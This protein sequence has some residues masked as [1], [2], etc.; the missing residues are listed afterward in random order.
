MSRSVTRMRA[1]ASPGGASSVLAPATSFVVTLQAA[2]FLMVLGLGFL[3]GWKAVIIES[4]SMRPVLSPGDIVLVKH[5]ERPEVGEVVLLD[6]PGE[7]LLFHRLVDWDEEGRAITR[8]D[9][10]EVEDGAATTPDRI[11][12]VG[13]VALPSIGLPALWL[14]QG[15]WGLVALSLL[16]EVAIFFLARLSTPV[17]RTHPTSRPSAAQRPPR[18]PAPRR[19]SSVALARLGHER[20]SM[21]GFSNASR[22]FE[23]RI[24]SPSS[25]RRCG[26][27]ACCSCLESSSASWR[28]LG[29]FDLDERTVALIATVVCLGVSTGLGVSPTAARATAASKSRSSLSW[30][31]ISSQLG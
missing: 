11:V 12:G 19:D 26:V 21:K 17:R 20:C 16:V 2:L 8:G 5:V 14:S 25:R 24:H 30:F 27:C 31:S 15:R 10:N 6:R 4:G 28:G 18:A 23:A 13:R 3:P 29:V 7:R 9:A 1:P 22:P